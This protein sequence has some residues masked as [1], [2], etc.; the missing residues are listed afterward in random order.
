MVVIVVHGMAVQV[1]SRDFGVMVPFGCC[2]YTSS[3]HGHLNVSGKLSIETGYMTLDD[4]CIPSGLGK[5][6]KMAP[7]VS[8]LAL[9]PH[10]L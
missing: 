6:T 5:K 2:V 3:S 9:V 4:Y 8:T 1:C 10:T 7:V